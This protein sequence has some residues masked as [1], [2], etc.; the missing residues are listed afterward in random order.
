[1]NAKLRAARNAWLLLLAISAISFL[2]AEL[3]GERHLA[4]GAI[5]LIAAVK[6]AVIL[7]RF[8][9]VESAPVAIRRYLFGW[10]FGIAA[11]VF[12]AWWVSAP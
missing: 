11:L 8:M 3:M 1:M 6:I 10:T 9:E 7:I 2:A 12:A 5:L 4:V